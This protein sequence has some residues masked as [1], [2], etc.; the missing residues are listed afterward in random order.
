MLVQKGFFRQAETVLRQLDHCSQAF[1]FN[2]AFLR[3][4]E[5]NYQA[6]FDLLEGNFRETE[7]FKIAERALL[8]QKPTK[9]CL[10]EYKV[11]D[12]YFQRTFTY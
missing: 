7:N 9:A 4:I 2:C 6:C 11:N 8:L 5:K 3:L 10:R 12:N 1:I